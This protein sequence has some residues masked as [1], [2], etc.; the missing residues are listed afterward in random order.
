MIIELNRQ[1]K[2]QEEKNQFIFSPRF[3]PL[4]KPDKG[5][6][7][8]SPDVLSLADDHQNSSVLAPI[9]NIAPL[10]SMLGSAIVGDRQSLMK[11]L[12]KVSGAQNRFFEAKDTQF[13][14]LHR[15]MEDKRYEPLGGASIDQSQSKSS[16]N[17]RQVPQSKQNINNQ[18]KTLEFEENE[19]N[20]LF[21][22]LYGSMSP[23]QMDEMAQRGFTF[24][25]P[26][27]LNRFYGSNSL[28]ITFNTSQ[29]ASMDELDRE[30][31]L[32]SFFS[33][34]GARN[35]SKR[36][37]VVLGASVLSP[38]IATGLVLTPIILHPL[39]L[40][41]LVLSPS[42]LG[43]LVLSP[44]VFAPFILSPGVLDAL[45]LS[46]AIGDPLVLS[47][48][49][50][51]PIILSPVL[52]S[53]FILSPLVLV[54]VVLSPL[55]LDPLVLSPYVL[56]PIVLSPIVLTPLILSPSVLS[57]IVK[58]PL[59]SGAKVLAPDFASPHV[60]SVKRNFTMFASP[61]MLS[62]R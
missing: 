7:F 45:I 26:K 56:S 15:N 34:L 55:V 5:A 16:R 49:V 47:P 12:M 41:P 40:S 1:A 11:L 46:P 28:N 25:A 33:A 3:M 30:E 20:K 29:Y 4:S 58:S 60:Q 42:V 53:P 44:S 39:V 57:P 62:R 50:L 13:R 24:M 14:V 37:A 8:L 59:V 23:S 6:R 22:Q 51:F 43:P 10:S 52:L 31:A 54:P 21:R 35:R 61:S 19:L 48:L 32:L 38:F 2:N 18:S 27:Q 36:A 17:V 9:D